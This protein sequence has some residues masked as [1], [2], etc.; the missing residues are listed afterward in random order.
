MKKLKKW[1]KAILSIAASVVIGVGAGVSLT[2]CKDEF[3]FT[4]NDTLAD[5]QGKKAKV[6]LLG[7]QSNASGCSRD[8]YLKKNVSDEKYLEYENGYDN[9]YINYFASGMNESKAFVKCANKQGE[10]GG[11]FGPELGLAEKL[12]ELYPN[13]LFFIIKYAWGG[14]NLFEQ[15]RS[16]SNLGKTGVLYQGFEAFVETSLKYLKEKNYDFIIEGMC[17]MQGESD[18]FSVENAT[19]YKD[20]LTYLIKDVRK[21]FTSY[22]GDNGIAFVDAYIADNPNYWVYCDLVNESKRQVAELSW[23]NVLIDTIAEGLTCSEEPEENPDMAHYD[24]MSQIK[25]G[26]LFAENVSQFFD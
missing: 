15:W 25:L 24:S 7:G 12:H 2:A 10:A 3:N 8:D 9:V 17:W 11:Y 21:K 18:S 6:I 19:N 16:P 4:I 23:S 26:H 1:A 22:A 14:T 13:E 5:G 20:N